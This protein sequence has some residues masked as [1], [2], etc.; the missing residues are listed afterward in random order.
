MLFKDIVVL[1]LLKDGSGFCLSCL[2]V[3]QF[4]FTIIWVNFCICLRSL[5]AIP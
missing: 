2:V 3:F 4:C 5:C 1:F